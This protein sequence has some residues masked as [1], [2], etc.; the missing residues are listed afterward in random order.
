M[1][2]AYYW[3]KGWFTIVEPVYTT[4]TCSYTCNTDSQNVLQ[5][6]VKLTHNKYGKNNKKSS[7]K[8]ILIR[9]QLKVEHN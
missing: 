2:N 7:M 5:C 3:S 8:G 4:G 1:V 9:K 6:T